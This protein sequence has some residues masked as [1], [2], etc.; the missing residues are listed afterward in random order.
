M[1]LMGARKVCESTKFCE[2]HEISYPPLSLN[3]KARVDTKF[4]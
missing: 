4:S 3:L 2:L 1:C